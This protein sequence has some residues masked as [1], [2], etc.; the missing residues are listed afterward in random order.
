MYWQAD[1]Y[2]RPLKSPTGEPIWELLL[3]SDDF[4]FSYGVFSPQG[5]VNADWVAEQL[6]IALEKSAAAP[7]AIQVFRP[8]CLSLLEAGAAALGLKVAPTRQTR[9]LKRWLEQRSR[10]YPSLDTYSSEPYNPEPD[11]PPPVPLSEDLWGDQWRFAALSAGDFERIFPHEPIPVRS[12]P[13]ALLPMQQGVP[14][15]I[16]IP[17]IVIDAGRKSMALAQWLQAAQPAWISYVP[18]DP[19]GLILDAGLVDRWVLTTFQD[20]DVAEAGRTFEHRKAEA[21]GI[22]FLLVRPDD[23][24]MTNTGIWLLQRTGLNQ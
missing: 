17:G 16:R 4:E 11:R 19:D 5:T 6:R 21:K 23:S 10:W 24:G 20:P 9:A 2:R 3:C 14:S 12:L 22:H 13:E 1:L 18:G 15:T 8:Q 7:E